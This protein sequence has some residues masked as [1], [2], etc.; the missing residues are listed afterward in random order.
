MTFSTLRFAAGSLF[1]AGG[2][3]VGTAANALITLPTQGLQANATLTFSVPAYTSSTAAGITISALGNTIQNED[4][5]VLDPESGI[6]DY[7]GQ[8]VFPVTKANV[9]IGWDLKIK[10]NWGA[11]VRSALKLTRGARYAV[12]ANFLVDFNQKVLFADFIKSNGETQLKQPLYTFVEVVPQ[13]IS[14]K[15]LVLNQSVTI[16]DLA[17]P[18]G[19]Q[20]FLGDELALSAPLRATLGAQRWGEIAILV[21]SYKR[22]PAVSTQPFTADDLPAAP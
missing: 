3:T 19:A 14:F 12:L 18:Q 16:G 13:K 15:N 9:T 10:A 17:L 7:V 2:L 21:T 8:F 6:T 4:V 5:G 11:S 22:S 20:D 1:L